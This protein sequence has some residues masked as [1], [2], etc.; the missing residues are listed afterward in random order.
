MT[1]QPVNFSTNQ[2]FYI[3]TKQ[4][5]LRPKFRF[6]NHLML[7]AFFDNVNKNVGPVLMW[8]F[9]LLMLIELLYVMIKYADG[10][11]DEKK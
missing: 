9:F 8:V 5:I 6:M 3:S 1:Y 2:L 11:V 10:A 4:P 7:S